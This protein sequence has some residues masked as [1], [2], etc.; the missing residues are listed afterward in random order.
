MP[1]FFSGKIDLERLNLCV[2][3]CSPAAVQLV[4]QGLFPCAPL[5]PTLA[6][7][8]RVLELVSGLFLRMSPNN[9]A[10]TSTLQDFLD[11][12]GYKLEGQ[13]CYLHH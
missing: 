6:V 10:I 12:R 9:T 1:N 8:I 7:D 4:S 5:W 2:C 3:E 11:S 13:V